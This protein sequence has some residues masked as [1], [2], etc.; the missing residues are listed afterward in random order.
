[1]KKLLASLIVSATVAATL[2]LTSAFA[3]PETVG[4]PQI[5]W[6]SVGTLSPAQGQTE[7][8]G[9][10]GMLSGNYNGYIIAGGGANFPNGG[11]AVGGPKKTYSDVYVFKASKEG[12]TEVDHQQMPF[13]IAYGMSVT[14]K[15][16]VYYI[17]GSTD[18]VGAKTI[19]RL[20]TDAKGK[21]KIEKVGELPFKIQNGV[22]GYANGA[23]Y[24][25]LGNQDGKA[26][27]D[28]YKFD[29]KSKELTKLAS[30]TGALREQSVSQILNNKLYVFG[31]G[32]NTALTDGYVYDIQKDAWDKVASVEVDNKA[33]SVYGGNSI[34]LNEDEML[35]IGG[36]NK[37]VYD[38]AVSNLGSLKDQE[39]ADFKAKY[40]GADVAEF[41]WN[42]QILVYNAKT[43]TWRSIGQIPFNAPCGEGLVYAGDSIIS[44]NGEVK[45]GVRSN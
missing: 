41:K 16:G 15:D 2:P 31:G 39:L 25:G 5:L 42:N 3:A 27:A 36:F 30:F 29:L 45:P 17:G 4:Q 13:E 23:L 12:L 43:N 19:T 26:S 21:L 7:N 32:T 9:V 24:I 38:W 20:T 28:F 8:I 34:K 6:Q 22:A 35:V 18:A 44:I 33:I 1:M 37:E 14:T 40:F 11:P 10:A